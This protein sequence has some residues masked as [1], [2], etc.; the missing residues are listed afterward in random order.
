MISQKS[1]AKE[2]IKAKRM[3]HASGVSHYAGFPQ[4]LGYIPAW[5]DLHHEPEG[6]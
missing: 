1:E 5:L 2:V 3:G 6:P 4:L